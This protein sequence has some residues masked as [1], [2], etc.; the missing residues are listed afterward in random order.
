MHITHLSLTNFRNYGR[1][2]LTLPQGP[3]L[4]YGNNAQGKTNLL[5]AV[6]YLATT[7]SPHADNDAQLLNWTAAQAE[8]PVIVGRLN[9]TVV[10]ARQTQTLEMRLIQEQKANYNRTRNFSFRREAL[11][12]RRKVRLMDLLGAMRVVLFLPEDVQLL[13]GSPAN[14]RRYMDITLCQIDPVYC[15][16]LS[17]YNKVLEQRNATLR[18][19]AE[20]Q[21]VRDVLPI[22]TDKLVELGSAI[23]LRRAAFVADISRE[24]QRI[25]YESLT[26]GQE[27]IK[28]VYLPRLSGKKSK[29]APREKQSPAV[30]ADWLETHQG[31]SELVSER[32]ARLLQESLAIDIARGATTVGPHRD[33]WSFQLN[34]R[35]LGS[36]GSRGQQRTAILAL[37]M[38][39]IN[40]MEAVTGERPILLLDEVVAELDENRRA[41]LLNSVTE[42]TQAILTATD[43][44]MFTE[45]FLQQATRMKVENGRIIVM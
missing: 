31:Q 38:G 25:H 24:T 19:L 43:P 7:R 11:L 27:S 23:F 1:L 30:L 20:G 16:T 35:S 33:D 18:Q 39:E 22:Y 32:F 37:K 12:D 8:E 21:P 15:R 45:P 26:N 28:L 42:T 40:W 10:T 5:E 41:A 3:V 29:I 14:R 4:L 9:A 34:G 17:N 2:E 6:Y 13:T 44:G 36:F